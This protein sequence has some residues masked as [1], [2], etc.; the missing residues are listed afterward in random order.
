VALFREPEVILFSEDV[1][2]AA[3]FYSRQGFVET[4][5]GTTTASIRFPKVSGQ[6]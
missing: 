2:R 6:R 1:E 5:R 4:F 3:R